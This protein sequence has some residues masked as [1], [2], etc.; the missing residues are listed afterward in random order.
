MKKITTVLAL[1]SVLAAATLVSCDT[2]EIQTPTASTVAE[3]TADG[4]TVEATVEASQETS[5]T[6]T[7][8][9]VEETSEE[10]AEEAT[11]APTEPDTEEE[12]TVK[13]IYETIQNPV[14]PTGND[15][16]VVTHEGKYYYCYS[17]P[18]WFFGG[19]GV[20][21]IPSLDKI[22]TEGGSQVYTA[23]AEEGADL[24]H[25]FEYWAPELHYIRGE[26][27]IYV[28]CDDGN[29]ETHRM[30]V[31]KGTSQDPTDP[32]EY[33]GQV[34][35]PTNK[36]AIDGTVMELDGELYFIWSGWEGDVNV[37]QNIYIA[38]MS[39]PCTIDSQRVCL[40]VPTYNWEKV[41]E[42]HVNEGPAVLQHDGKTFVVYSASGSWTDNYCLGMLTL[43]GDDP[44]NTDHWEKS[45]SPVFRKQTGVCY[46][47]G[48]C[49]FTTA[50]DG[51]V[52]MVYHGNLKSGTGWEGRSV[53]IS[54]VTF[55]EN[56]NPDFGKP[57]KEVQFPVGV[58]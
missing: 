50:V 4:E 34:T 3:S 49:S 54:P 16:W 15:P 2:N 25:S 8:P 31:L 58:E 1:L 55:D 19:V 44:L 42:P 7:E 26:W 30:Y 12:T 41:G 32:F 35:D 57:E 9:P 53:W 40:S 5:E 14:A 51:S 23:P 29:N 39:D 13:V 27:Y 6:P 52:W 47:P 28:A 36:W 18:V 21:E 24:S 22:S 11:E 48:H 37:A 33:V 43:T 38:H 46:G 45:T 56:G 20:A 10:T 17:S